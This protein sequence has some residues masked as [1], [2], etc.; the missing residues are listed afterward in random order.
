VKI[1]P[2]KQAMKILA[3][4]PSFKKRRFDMGK[5][6]WK[7]SEKHYIGDEVP[8]IANVKAV[9]VER[10]QDSYGPYAALVSIS[11]R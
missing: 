4:N 7:G 2:K 8:D 11:A 5:Y 10:R 3:E 1:I 6:E 9:F